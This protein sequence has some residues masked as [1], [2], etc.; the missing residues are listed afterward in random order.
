[1]LE[2]S[3]K[4]QEVLEI[5]ENSIVRF[6]RLACRIFRSA[7]SNHTKK[8]GP[9][10]PSPPPPIQEEAPQGKK[11]KEKHKAK[12]RLEEKP[13]EVKERGRDLERHKEKKEKQR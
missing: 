12:E 4:G 2:H 3:C 8:K 7:K 5:F 9:R 13:R 10:T 6:K 11:H 1:M